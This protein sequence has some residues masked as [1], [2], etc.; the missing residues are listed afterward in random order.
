M[1]VSRRLL[2]PIA[3][4]D[5]HNAV[6]S[7]DLNAFVTR[8]LLF[9]TL[10][11]Q[12]VWLKDVLLLSQVFGAN[13]L[14]QLFQAGAL[15]LVCE[16]FA[17]GETGRTRADLNF[18]DNNKRLPL[19][20]YS[21]SVLRVQEQ[22]RKI[23]EAISRLEPSL[24]EQVSANLLQVNPRKFSKTVFESFYGDLRG[25]PA[26]VKSAVEVELRRLGI[27][28][29]KLAMSI[30]EVD[31]EDF[32]VESN[33]S[34]E[35]GLSQSKAHHVVERSLLAVSGLNQRIA[36]MM[37]HSALSGIT[38]AD[39][40]LMGGKLGFLAGLVGAQGDAEHRF[41]RV[42][43]L[44]GLPSPTF[45]SVRVD[46]QKLLKLRESDECRAFRDWLSQ[47]DALSDMEIQSRVAGL[48]SKIRAVVNGRIGKAIRFMVSNGLSFAGP[49][50]GVASLGASA[51]DSFLLEKLAPKDSVVSFLS[52][53]YPSVFNP[54]KP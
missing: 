22:E 51:V 11:L 40:P 7:I 4:Q 14:S 2:A 10:V 25:N 49:L 42:A 6:T 9:D 5:R 53:S 46:A 29:K 20:S 8:V 36:E 52:E 34:S 43:T 44:T 41:E 30:S 1:N 19:G 32:R 45:G 23:D 31:P 12:S 33:L 50:G 35:Y 54:R 26:V 48:S 37:E 3:I 27:K 28:P 39:F 24:Q 15:K 13:G 18:T 21:F 47:T 16:S 17:V 38:D